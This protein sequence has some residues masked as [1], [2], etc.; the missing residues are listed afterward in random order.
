LRPQ[1]WLAPALPPFSLEEYI[2]R[3]EK[4]FWQ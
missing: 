3:K 1:L 2:A 4:T